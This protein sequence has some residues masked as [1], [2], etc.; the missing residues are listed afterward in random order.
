MANPKSIYYPFAIDRS[1]GRLMEETDHARHVEQ[2]IKQVLLTNRGGDRINRPDFGSDIRRMVFS[3]SNEVNA[4]L[5][6]VIILQA[7]ERWLSFVIS[8][9]E[10]KVTAVNER[11]QIGIKYL[12]IVKQEKRYLNLEVK[13]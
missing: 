8:V 2:M 4:N 1:L 11:L 10:V 7:L 9:T 3:G 13:V 5:A 6:Q 12:L